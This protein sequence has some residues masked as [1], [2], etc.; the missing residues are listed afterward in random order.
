MNR[1]KQL[2]KE[3]DGSRNEISELEREEDEINKLLSQPEIAADYVRVNKLIKK[4]EG[5]KLQ[6]DGLYSKYSEMI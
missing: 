2:K 1:K 4:S 5:I 6:L 3:I